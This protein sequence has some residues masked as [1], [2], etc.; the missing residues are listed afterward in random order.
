MGK[1]DMR[2]GVSRIS[3]SVPPLLLRRFDEAFRR[4]GYTD[5]SKAVQNAMQSFVIE[6]KWPCSKGGRGVGAIMLVYDSGVR[7]VVETIIDTQQKYRRI[8]ESSINLHVDENCLQIIPVRGGAAQEV[9]GR[10]ACDNR[11]HKGSQAGNS[12]SLDQLEA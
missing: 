4:L 10:G 6:S 11:W 1:T 8:A 9:S 5:R 7:Q 12:D 2:E 3:V